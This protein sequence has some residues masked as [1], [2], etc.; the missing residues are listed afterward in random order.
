MK[1]S[2]IDGELMG[3]TC[4]NSVAAYLYQ[5]ERFSGA[6]F[7]R[8]ILMQPKNTFAPLVDYLHV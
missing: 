6:C 8:H 7:S 1:I 2:A 4:L 3:E 5:Y